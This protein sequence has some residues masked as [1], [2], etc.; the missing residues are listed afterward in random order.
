M[1][2]RILQLLRLPPGSTLGRDCGIA[3]ALL[4]PIFLPPHDSSSSAETSRNFR[5]SVWRVS[6]SI[7]R[8]KLDRRV[9]QCHSL[10]QEGRCDANA[11][12]RAM[13][14][15]NQGRK[16][17][18]AAAGVPSTRA[19]VHGEQHVRLMGASPG[20]TTGAR[21]AVLRTTDGG[22]L[23]LEELTAHKTQHQAGL[24]HRRVPEQHKLE[25]E[26]FR[27][28]SHVARLVALDTGNCSARPSA[29]LCG[30]GESRSLAEYVRDPCTLLDSIID[31]IP[32][33]STAARTI[34]HRFSQQG[35]SKPCQVA[36]FSRSGHSTPMA[37]GS[38]AASVGS[39]VIF[40]PAVA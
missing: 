32:H 1:L 30:S 6:K 11:K 31:S 16:I 26:N 18:A 2:Y 5:G 28:R 13:Q 3:P 15:K 14:T 23:V 4:Y 33:I 8:T 25:L 40:A 10:S 20:E 17:S 37:G 36:R 38:A 35:S 22:L 29:R 34:L 27:R 21:Q 39:A 7:E 9:V 19:P 24:S 12:S